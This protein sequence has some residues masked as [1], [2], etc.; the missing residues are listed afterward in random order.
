MQPQPPSSRWPTNAIVITIVLALIAGLLGAVVAVR[1][2]QVNRLEDQVVSLGADLD[3]AEERID[4]LES[5]LD[6]ASSSTDGG[7]GGLGDLLGD[8]LGGDGGS[9]S[10]DDLLGGILGGESGNLEMGSMTSLAA[11]ATSAARASTW[12]P[13]SPAEPGSIEISDADLESQIDDISAAVVEIRELDFPAPIEPIL[14][15][16][17]EMSTRVRDLTEEALVDDVVDFETR[18]WIALGMLEPGTDL[19]A[20]QIDLLDSAV[21]GYYDPETEEL[22]VATNSSDTPLSATDQVTL[23]HELIHALTDARLGFPDSINDPRTDPERARA[24]QALIEGDATLGMQQFSLGALDLMDQF[25]MLLDPRIAASQQDLEEMPFILSNGLQLP[26]LEG[27]NFTCSLFSEGGWDAVDAAYDNPPSTTIE[28]LFPELYAQGF[29][30][31]QPEQAGNPGHRL[32]RAE[33]RRVSARSILLNLFS[34]PGDNTDAALDEVRPRLRAWGGGE[35]TVWTRGEGTAVLLN[36]V[37]SGESDTSLC[38]SMTE[39]VE[40]ADIDQS[41]LRLSC[42][43]DS[44]RVAIAPDLVMADDIVG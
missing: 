2:G 22:V 36:L 7:L 39:W 5:Q 31:T 25:G 35:A 16:P 28:I 32:D 6:Q 10:L 8:L 20:T 42:T 15:S 23:A 1:S 38:D 4:D 17:E 11:W 37:D 19:A 27:M 18:L 14:V 34:A 26:Y 33:H 29:E 12:P 43:G 21:A 3:S 41:T 24:L 30:A 9:S 40:A 13:A 44:V